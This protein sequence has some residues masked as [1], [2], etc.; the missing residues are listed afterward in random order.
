MNE[1]VTYQI[2]NDRLAELRAEVADS[3]RRPQRTRRVF[4]FRTANPVLTPATR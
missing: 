1:Y 2:A 3:R 4:R